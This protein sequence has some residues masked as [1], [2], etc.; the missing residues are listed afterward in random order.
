VKLELSPA[1]T[2][3][4]QS[5]TVYTFRTWGEFQADRYLE[6]IWATLENIRQ[7]PES[8]RLRS[9]LASEC[10]S[11][12]VGRHVIFFTVQGDTV[13]VLR[14]LHSSMNFNSHF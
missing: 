10:R 14:I 12:L 13:G 3:D 4:I 7:R 1:A 8:F 6:T 2:E 5:I 11:A 9:E